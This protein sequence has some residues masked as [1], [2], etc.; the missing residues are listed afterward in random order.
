VELLQNNVEIERLNS[1]T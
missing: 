1:S